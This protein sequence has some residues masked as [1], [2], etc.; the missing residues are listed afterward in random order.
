MVPSTVDK[1]VKIRSLT[2]KEV[3]SLAICDFENADDPVKVINNL[4]VTCS[5]LPAIKNEIC[6]K[7]FLDILL[8]SEIEVGEDIKESLFRISSVAS[9]FPRIFSDSNE[10]PE[11]KEEIQE[12]YLKV[13]LDIQYDLNGL[14]KDK[15]KMYQYLHLGIE[16]VDK[17]PF[18]EFNFYLKNLKIK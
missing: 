2:V 17:L 4:V 3:Q 9:T 7:L 18:W 16:E 6:G 1:T 11:L 8:L 5:S 14:L 12:L 10:R 13:A 15:M